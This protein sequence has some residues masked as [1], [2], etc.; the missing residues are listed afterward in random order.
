VGGGGGGSK[1]Q[2]QPIVNGLLE[3]YSRKQFSILRR[4]T[5]PVSFLVSGEACQR[6]SEAKSCCDHKQYRYIYF[7]YK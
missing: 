7:R 1:A 2:F 4:E 3:L 5:L 6:P